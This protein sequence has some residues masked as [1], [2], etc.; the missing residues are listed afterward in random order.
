[1]GTYKY[2]FQTMFA[3][4]RKQQASQASKPRAKRRLLQH[5]RAGSFFGAATLN[6]SAEV[7]PRVWNQ[8]EQVSSSSALYA[9]QADAL[10]IHIL[11]C[12]QAWWETST[13][14]VTYF[15]DFNL[16]IEIY[17]YISNHIFVD[18]LLDILCI[19]ICVY[20]SIYIQIYLYIRLNLF[21]VRRKASQG[22]K[23][24]QDRNAMLSIKTHKHSFS[25]T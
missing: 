19:Y 15:A 6:S 18:M 7:K 13:Y 23:V 21:F 2:Q 12:D 8:K 10:E 1:L 3:N 20:S 22:T 25:W 4:F 5:L 9:E 16:R 11:L 24:L 14:T 17:L